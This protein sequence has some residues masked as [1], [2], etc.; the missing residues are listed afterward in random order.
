MFDIQ[1]TSFFLNEGDAEAKRRILNSALTLFL[2]K[3]MCETT[4]R[5]IAD[6]TGF[7]NPAL[8]KHFKSKDAVALYLFESCYR[9]LVKE[10]AK[11]LSNYQGFDARLEA[12]ITA[13][14]AL[15]EF[16]PRPI[17]YVNDNLRHFWPSLTKSAKAKSI[18]T[19]QH[20]LIRLGQEEQKVDNSL[21]LEFAV[22]LL[23]GTLGQTARMAYFKAMRGRPREWTSELTRMIKRALQA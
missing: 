13:Y 5:D 11:I 14:C 21:S 18:L 20:E 1:F 17:L 4:I 19:Q 9:G 23:G 2:E 16:D 15:L 7:S 3:G 22:A 8:Y 12:Y 10:T 6:E